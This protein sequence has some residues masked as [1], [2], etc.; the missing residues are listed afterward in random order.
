MFFVT[1]NGK[2]W[3]DYN[4][5]TFEPEFFNANLTVL[6]PDADKRATAIGLCNGGAATDDNPEA[7]RECYF[8]FL[9]SALW[10]YKTLFRLYLV[11][12]V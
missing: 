2:N 3:S 9:V 10:I 6:F 8:D 7:R 1:A 5:P 4:D 11:I 12:Q